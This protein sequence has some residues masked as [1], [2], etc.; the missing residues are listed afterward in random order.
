M[1][2]VIKVLNNPAPGTPGG[3]SLLLQG[4]A[5]VQITLAGLTPLGGDP[6]ESE[7]RQ[8]LVEQA[9]RAL[10]DAAQSIIE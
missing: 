9:R 8:H 6:R 2:Y 3:A 10:T 4:P 7:I 1:S 5:G